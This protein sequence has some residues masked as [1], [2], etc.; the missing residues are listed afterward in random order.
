MTS[1]TSIPATERFWSTLIGY[2]RLGRVIPIVGQELVT[3]EREGST[4]RVMDAVASQLMQELADEGKI[5]EK[6]R[7]TGE[8]SCTLT[9]IIGQLTD[10]RDRTECLARAHELLREMCQ[11][12]PVPKP[13]RQLA[14]IEP[15]RLFVS[16]TVE[17]L[18]AEHLHRTVSG[19]LLPWQ[20]PAWCPVLESGRADLDRPSPFDAP[21]VF[22]LLGVS[23]CLPETA[24]VT[25]DQ[26]IEFVAVLH[27]P[28]RRPPKLFDELRTH[29]LLLLGTGFPDWLARFFIRLL[30]GESFSL[31]TTT[32]SEYLAEPEAQPGSRL[33]VFLERYSQKTRICP[34]DTAA[35]F[36]AEL[37]R[38]WKA[39]AKSAGDPKPGGVFISYSRADLAAVERI[40][41]RLDKAAIPF[42][43]DRRE[44]QP[45]DPFWN[46]IER[47]ISMS[48]I[49]MP[50]LSSTTRQRTE[51]CQGKRRELGFWR[52]WL[53]AVD[54]LQPSGSGDTLR[55]VMPVVVD[56]SFNSHADYVP[57]PFRERNFAHAPC[58]EAPD[59]LLRAINRHLATTNPLASA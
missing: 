16:T 54:C 23:S 9:S 32:T 12:L 45:G 37:H 52:E 5:G 43:F 17:G 29:H 10:P 39:T 36:V 21:I 34:C 2:I 13:L 57:E 19:G 49:F 31:S 42:W 15:F 56:P 8:D 24:A 14:D 35:D 38:R 40:A 46:V 55:G 6:A 27:D 22:Q 18:L 53:H 47:N 30:K 26:I 50:V 41:A 3:V 7:N 33:A 44:L 28:L 20:R 48:G 25:D 4:V 58:G 59:E 1:G 51:A 11:G